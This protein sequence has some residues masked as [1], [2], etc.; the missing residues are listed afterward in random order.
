MSTSATKTQVEPGTYAID[1]IHSTVGF[2]VEHLGISRFRGR[3]RDF[4]GSLRFDESG[5]LTGVEGE[6]EVTSVDV[7]EEMLAQHLRSEEFFWTERYPKARFSATRIE[8]TGEGRWRVE[9]NFE[10]RGATHPVALDVELRGATVDMQ[11]K[12][13]VSLAAQGAL[14]RKQW[15]LSWDATLENGTKVLGDEVTL[16]LEVEAQKQ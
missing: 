1:P 3:F 11:G 16:V 6:I 13:R 12:P 8:R 2:E 15:G 9:G 5:E 14:D 4:S 10:L 7:R